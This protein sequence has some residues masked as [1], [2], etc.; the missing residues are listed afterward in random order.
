MSSFVRG[1]RFALAVFAVL[2]LARIGFEF[3]AR[4]VSAP[5]LDVPIA[6]SAKG[7]VD[8]RIRIRVPDR[9]TL[10]LDF[11]ADERGFSYL[12]G[13]LDEAKLPPNDEVIY[14]GMRVP[15]RWSLRETV[16]GLI[17][18]EGETETSGKSSS[19]SDSITQNV[20][21]LAVKPGDYRLQARILH[22][23][24]ELAGIDARLTMRLHPKSVGS[25]QTSLAWNGRLATLLVDPLLLLLGLFLLWRWIRFGIAAKRLAD[26][27][28]E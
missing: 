25:W 17:V 28:H 27:A 19:S 8:Q 15:L 11:H 18:A 13:L 2:L 22:D 14:H 9:Y 26:T 12:D 20:G 10:A 4:S 16:G 1:N 7:A 24:P 23:L 3:W 5:P 6:I 21:A